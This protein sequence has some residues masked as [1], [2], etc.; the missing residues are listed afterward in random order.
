MLRR[1]EKPFVII[2]ITEYSLKGKIYR[3]KGVIYPGCQFLEDEQIVIKM[4]LL[5]QY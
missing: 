3:F 1:M 4:L 5:Y 2:M